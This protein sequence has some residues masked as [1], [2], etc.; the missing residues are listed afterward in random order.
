MIWDVERKQRDSNIKI[1]SNKQLDKTI[2]L[3]MFCA[4]GLWH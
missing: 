1:D 2:F 4:T 3:K